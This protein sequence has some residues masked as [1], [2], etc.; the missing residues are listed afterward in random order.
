M[1]EDLSYQEQ[2]AAAKQ[3]LVGELADMVL[4]ADIL[5]DT[6][7]GNVEA[8]Q[9]ARFQLARCLDSFIT[10]VRHVCWQTQSTPSNLRG[11]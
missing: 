5:L 8:P 4:P 2:S 1:F 6:A 7:N 10:R 11:V 9:D 3:L